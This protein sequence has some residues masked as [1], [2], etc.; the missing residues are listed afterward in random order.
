MDK[1]AKTKFKDKHRNIIH[2]G[3]RLVLKTSWSVGDLFCKVINEKQIEWEKEVNL[4]TELEY[5]TK[6]LVLV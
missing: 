1:K 5:W 2:V 6:H 3:D 4:R